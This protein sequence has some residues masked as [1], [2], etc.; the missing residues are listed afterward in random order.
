MEN[1]V[2]K[3]VS[4]EVKR[5]KRLLGLNFWEIKV[6]WT[7]E[8]DDA[9]ADCNAEPEYYKAS[10]GFN[11]EKLKGSTPKQL[12]RIV[13]HELMHVVLSPYANIAALVGGE[14]GGKV[15]EKLEERLIED[16]TMNMKWEKMK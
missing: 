5:W 16:I 4:D 9:Y 1:R 12:R 13:F 15:L 6:G 11:L 10:I 3:L 8:S 7:V 14:T 2:Q